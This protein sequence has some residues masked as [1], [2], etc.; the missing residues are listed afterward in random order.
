[1]SRRL[2]NIDRKSPMLL[3]LD[4]RVWVKRGELAEFILD[5]VEVMDLSSAMLNKR[6]SG[7]L[8]YPPGMMLAVLLYCYAQGIFSSR[9]IE[10]AT[11]QHVSVRYLA[12]NTHP[13][14]DTIAKFRRENGELLRSAFVQLLQLAQQTGVLQ[15]GLIAIDGTKVKASAAKRKTQSLAQ[16]EEQLQKLEI[17]VSELLACAEA[18]DADPASKHDD[19]PKELRDAQERRE[20]LLAAKA[21]LNQQAKERYER[22]ERE[23]APN[24][25]APQG[26]KR[27]NS[28]APKP[29]DKINPTDPQSVL[30]PGKQGGYLQGYNTQLAVALSEKGSVSLIV[31]TDVVRE[32]NDIL[33]LEPLTNQ[34]VENVQQA[35][36]TILADKGYSNTRQILS[37]E[38]RHETTVLCPQVQIARTKSESVWRTPWD[39]QRQEARAVMRK[40]L[41][42]PAQKAL[43]GRRNTSVEPAIGIIKNTIGF[44]QF[45]LRGL[46]KVRLE[47][48]L[49]SL[50][51]NC[52]RLAAAGV[53][54]N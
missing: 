15:V 16:I 32:T 43:Y 3:P 42:D 31:A 4:L 53:K 17:K 39:R 2:V 48:T 6:G 27:G 10:R 36:G 24:G 25:V 38:R 9:Q 45:R 54:F 13:D 14:H 50:A 19:L 26:K 51:F 52:R 8:Q 44:Q 33:Q 35:P 28:P 40:R 22:R 5:A 18:A 23:R 34:V 46:N 21:A 11:H 30:M 29:T 49:V 7:S 47:W 41:E 1:M 37:V 12:G 20:R